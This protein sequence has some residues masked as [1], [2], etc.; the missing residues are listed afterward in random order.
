GLKTMEGVLES[1]PRN[2]KLLLALASGFTQYGYAFVAADAEVADFQDRLAEAKALRARARRLFI[3]AR[4]YGL[5]GLDERRDGLG[6]RL[7]AGGG[8]ADALATARKEDV[9]LLYWTA[10]AWTLAIVNA[11]GDM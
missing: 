4:D 2:E 7:R 9:P 8:L 10:S 6:A 11:K 3:R 5:R 1:E